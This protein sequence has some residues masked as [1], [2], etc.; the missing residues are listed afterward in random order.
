MGEF[1][2]LDRRLTRTRMR[3]L[4]KSRCF[5]NDKFQAATGQLD[6]LGYGET[7]CREFPILTHARS[8]LITYP[9]FEE[10]WNFGG[11]GRDAFV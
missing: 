9:Q 10:E 6:T 1:S 4:A 5:W 8:S 2:N 3:S 11:R 7:S